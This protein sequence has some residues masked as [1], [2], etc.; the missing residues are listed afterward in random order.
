VDRDENAAKN[1]RD[2]PDH[3]NPGSVGASA[4]LD[5]GPR[6]SGTDGGSDA[7]VTGHLARRRK[8]N[9][10]LAAVGEARTKARKSE[11]RN[12]AMGASGRDH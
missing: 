6:S 8:T 9:L 12:P 3:A 4:L 11:Q 5:P 10:G 2:W 1:L 7:R